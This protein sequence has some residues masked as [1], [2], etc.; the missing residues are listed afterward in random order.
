MHLQK[1]GVT[2]QIMDLLSEKLKTGLIK[3]IKTQLDELPK[4]T[5]ALSILCP[6]L[7]KKEL[8]EA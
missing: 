8:T 5:S 4:H 6:E 1:A 3:P 2:K 7:S